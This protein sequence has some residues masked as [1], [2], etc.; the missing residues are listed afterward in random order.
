MDRKVGALGVSFL[1]LPAT[2][3]SATCGST[4]SG[5]AAD[6]ETDEPPD[7][8]AAVEPGDRPSRISSTVR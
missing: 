3:S 8:L 4:A 2:A 1:A 5:L 7:L 6:L